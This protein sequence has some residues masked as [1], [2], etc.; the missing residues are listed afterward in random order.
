MSCALL[1]DKQCREVQYEAKKLKED[2]L[3]GKEFLTLDREKLTLDNVTNCNQNQ[4][5]NNNIC[6][7]SESGSVDREGAQERAGA[8]LVN[9]EVSPYQYQQCLVCLRV[10]PLLEIDHLKLEKGLIE[11]ATASTIGQFEYESCITTDGINIVSSSKPTGKQNLTGVSNVDVS[12]DIQQENRKYVQKAE[13]NLSKPMCQSIQERGRVAVISENR[14]LAIRGNLKSHINKMNE[15]PQKTIPNNNILPL[16][17]TFYQAH[18]VF[19]PHVTDF[20]LFHS[21]IEPL[22][23]RSLTLQEKVTII[24]YGQ[25][26]A[27]KTHTSTLLQRNVGNYL[28]N[29]LHLAQSSVSNNRKQKI[30]IYISFFEIKGEKCSDLLNF[31]NELRLQDN[32]NGEIVVGNLHS[33]KVNSVKDIQELLK[34][35]NELR[36]MRPTKSND[37]SSRSHSICDFT[38]YLDNNNEAVAQY[39]DLKLSQK[40]DETSIHDSMVLA[41]SIRIVDLAGSERREDAIEHDLERI[42]EMKETNF[43]LAC[44]KDCIH[45]KLK[46]SRVLLAGTKYSSSTSTEEKSNI[47]IPYR[48]SKLTMLLKNCFDSVAIDSNK[49]HQKIDQVQ[50]TAVAGSGNS[51]CF[52]AHLAPLRSQYK[53]T[54]ST[55][56][57]VK[58]MIEISMLSKQKSSFLDVEKWSPKQ[59]MKWVEKLENGKFSRCSS[60]FARCSGKMFAITWRGDIIKW[61]QAAGGNE[62]D[63][64]YI[65]DQFHALLKEAKKGKL[66][67]KTTFEKSKM[68]SKKIEDGRKDVRMSELRS[69]DSSENKV[70][71]EDVADSKYGPLAIQR[72]HVRSDKMRGHVDIERLNEQRKDMKFIKQKLMNKMKINVK[73]VSMI[74]EETKDSVISSKYDSAVINLLESQTKTP[75]SDVT[76]AA[77]NQSSTLVP[78]SSSHSSEAVLNNSKTTNLAITKMKM[79]STK[80][81]HSSDP[82]LEYSREDIKPLLHS[83][84]KK[85]SSS[86]IPSS[87]SISAKNSGTKT[88]DKEGEV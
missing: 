50:N 59:V 87:V 62:H 31:K 71:H 22:V 72:S 41:G 37:R 82:I 56:T 23:Y 77:S 68:L 47:H 10:R 65:Y 46:K 64:E 45:A 8:T 34:E 5:S 15:N 27:G 78:T 1:T 67:S 36:S 86:S 52:I 70:E 4:T 33:V 73:E 11:G 88:F 42:K 58:E 57:Y 2:L 74:K 75:E 85:I 81:C 84:K 29:N 44:L 30:S 63:G 43:S 35:G 19:G 79:A 7:E 14:S 28:F 39:D 61:V 26:G 54:V 66:K 25:T 40:R 38:L 3:Q 48:R 32:G 17:T 80:A 60:A 24:C 55:L 21:T 13:E 69:N 18:E 53:H 12:Q 16:N 49:I 6:I 20:T 51:V 9:L 83:L 76:F